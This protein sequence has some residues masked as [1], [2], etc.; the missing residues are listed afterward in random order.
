MNLKRNNQVKVTAWYNTD[1]ICN[2]NW[3]VHSSDSDDEIYIVVK[4]P[5]T[6]TELKIKIEK[7]P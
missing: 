6:N 1:L 7:L 5:M 3:H 2:Q 4:D